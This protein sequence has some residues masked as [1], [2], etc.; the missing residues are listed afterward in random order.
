[1]SIKE[2]K[3]FEN[4]AAFYLYLD[5]LF[6]EDI[7]DDQ[8]FASSYLRGFISLSVIEFGDESQVLSPAL[9]TSIDEKLQAARTEL[10]PQD[11]KIVQDYWLDLKQSFVSV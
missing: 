2:K 1:M 9:A 11:R 5:N 6:D 7:S 4:I 8:L 3:S 10:S